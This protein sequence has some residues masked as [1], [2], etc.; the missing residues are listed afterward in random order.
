MTTWTNAD[1]APLDRAL[2]TWAVTGR[3][4]FLP[5]RTLRGRVTFE[6]IEGG[7]FVR[8]RS[9]MD[10]PEFPR[11]VAIFG[12]DDEAGG[13]T[14]LAFDDRGVARRY[15]VVLSADGFTWSRDAP[16]FAQRFQVEIAKDGRRMEGKGTMSREG[17]PWE[18]DLDLTYEK[19]D[20]PTGSP[21]LVSARVFP[22]PAEA[23]FAAFEDPR[24]LARWW[25]PAGARNEFAE[26]DLRAGGKWRST[27]TMPDGARYPMDKTFVEVARPRRIVVAHHQAGHDFT[28]TMDYEEVSGGTRL[29]WR[30]RFA[31]PEQLAA[32]EQAFAAAN[33]QNFDRLAAEMDG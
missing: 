3:H 31:T 22:F 25:G 7:A 11:G 5:G 32:V 8:M 29:T 17:K 28:M 13:C 27:M 16:S 30:T 15:E 23:L 18:P 1:L 26:F 24:R 9:Q 33:E 21:E 19:V 20:E 4:P 2:G 12:T 6:R 14:M 10:E